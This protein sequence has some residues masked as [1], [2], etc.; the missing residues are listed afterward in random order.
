MRVVLAIDLKK[1]YVVH[2]R[3]GDR[4]TY[5]PLTWGLAHSAEPSS[6]LVEM[7]PKYLYIADLD[8]IGRCG[9]HTK[10]IL[11]LADKV[12]EL[13]VDRGCRTPEEYLQKENIHNIVGTE[14]IEASPKDFNGGFLSVDVIDE[15]VIGPTFSPE[16]RP[17]EVLCKTNE[18]N[19]DGCILLNISSVGT[20][21]G[22]DYAYAE[23]L[24]SSSS[25][26]LYYG[27]GVRSIDDLQILSDAGFDGVI[28]S[29]AVHR[30]TVPLEIIRKGSFC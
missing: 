11:Q 7:K 6:Y 14:T 8:R 2:G 24:R 9:D 4:N 15:H 22:I 30:R 23:Q 28:V 26:K 27:G 20:S 5:M 29:T 16:T 3:S 25:K 21:S 12:V 1:G 10:Q 17:T 18:T 13:W 19:F